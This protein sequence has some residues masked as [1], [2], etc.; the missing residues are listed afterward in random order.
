MLQRFGRLTDSET[1]LSS[2]LFG[3]GNK[4]FWFRWSFANNFGTRRTYQVSF[5]HNQQMRP[6]R[7]LEGKVVRGRLMVHEQLEGQVDL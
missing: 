7:G 4:E 6:G 5:T 1:F 2:S 3:N